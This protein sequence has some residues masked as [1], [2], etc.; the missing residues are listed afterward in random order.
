MLK[1]DIQ[2]ASEQH[3][4]TKPFDSAEMIKAVQ[5]LIE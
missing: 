1:Q 3:T 4:F 2:N 5:N